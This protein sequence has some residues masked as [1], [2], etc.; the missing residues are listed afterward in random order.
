MTNPFRKPTP[1]RLA[2][3]ELEDAQRALLAASSAAEY[4]RAMVGYHQARIERLRAVIVELL[5]EEDGK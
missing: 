5:T 2:V 1:A 4:A 3:E